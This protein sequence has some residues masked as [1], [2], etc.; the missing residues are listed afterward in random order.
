MYINPTLLFLLASAR[1]V[2]CTYRWFCND[3]NAIIC[4]VNVLFVTTKIKKRPSHPTQ[5]LYNCNIRKWYGLRWFNTG[6]KVD[7]W[8]GESIGS[9]RLTR[10][11]SR[12]VKF[13]G[14]DC[15]GNV[16]QVCTKRY[17]CCCVLQETPGSISAVDQWRKLQRAKCFEVV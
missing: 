2:V 10:L 1:H 4:T 17:C 11:Y 6:S 16:D 8:E 15:R 13:C 12:W 5:I 14:R 9:L 3:I 7:C